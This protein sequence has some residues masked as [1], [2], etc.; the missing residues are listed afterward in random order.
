[1]RIEPNVPKTGLFMFFMNSIIRVKYN[2]MH[3][4]KPKDLTIETLTK[5]QGIHENKVIT[6]A[7]VS[8]AA[9]RKYL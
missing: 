4:K 9:Y 7:Q 1:M 3:Q 8:L 5:H 2:Q 6:N